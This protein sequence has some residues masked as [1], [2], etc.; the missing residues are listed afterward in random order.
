MESK[1]VKFY[2]K[3]GGGWGSIINCETRAKIIQALPLNSHY[4]TKKQDFLAIGPK[5]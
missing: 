1:A 4:L 2:R 3:T 5:S